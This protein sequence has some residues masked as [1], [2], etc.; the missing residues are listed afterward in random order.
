MP[1]FTLIKHADSAYDAEVKVEFQA[2]VLDLARSHYEDFLQASGFQLPDSA[3]QFSEWLDQKDDDMWDDAFES[4]FSYAAPG[5]VLKSD[6][7]VGASGNDVIF[8]GDYKKESFIPT[9]HD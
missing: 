7:P 1:R 3:E 2:E 9:F 4:K 5:P 8:L 6:G